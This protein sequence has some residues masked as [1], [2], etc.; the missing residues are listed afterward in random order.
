MF[1]QPFFRQPVTNSIYKELET[2][3]SSVAPLLQREDSKMNEVETQL[4]DLYQEIMRPFKNFEVD[5]N[6]EW[7]IDYLFQKHIKAAH[8]NKI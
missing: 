1:K 8:S 5:D 6:E 2:E 3:L 4:P 7:T